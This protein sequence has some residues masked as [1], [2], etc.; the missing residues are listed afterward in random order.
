MRVFL[1]PLLASLL[2]APLATAR[3]GNHTT[4]VGNQRHNGTSR[5]LTNETQVLGPVDPSYRGRRAA[6]RTRDFAAPVYNISAFYAES[7]VGGFPAPLKTDM[8]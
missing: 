2:L 8:S 4:R 1:F 5:S 3:R 7:Q 6:R